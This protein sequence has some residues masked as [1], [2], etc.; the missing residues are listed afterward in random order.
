MARKT[1]D[2]PAPS[3]ALATKSKADLVDYNAQLLAACQDQTTDFDQ[4]DLS[5]PRVKLLQALSPE[6]V[7]ADPAYIKAARPGDILLA[8]GTLLEGDTGFTFIPAAYKR[9]GLIFQ[10]KPKR[11]FVANLGQSYDAVLATCTNGPDG[12]KITP[13]GNELVETATYFGFAIA[14]GGDPQPC[15]ISLNKSQWKVAKKLN[16]L[17]QQYREKTPDG[18]M[19]IPPIYWRSW[20]LTTDATSND[21]GSWFIF[22]PKPEAKVL[23]MENGLA[24]LEAAKQFREEIM[25]GRKVANHEDMGE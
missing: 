9:E 24:L 10:A 19:V 11:G 15:V 23:E 5:V 13:E 1:N 22:S 4:K 7:K 14:P 3:T 25:A 17:I 12:E 6:L 21:K 20:H 8:D 18:R 16:T 2:S